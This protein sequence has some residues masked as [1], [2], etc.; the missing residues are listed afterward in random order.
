[1]IS[2]R[3]KYE[4]ICRYFFSTVLFLV[5]LP[6]LTTAQRIIG[7]VIDIETRKPVPEMSIENLYTNTV[8]TTN[9]D[10]KFDINATNGQLLEFK[11]AGYKTTRVRIP[12][13]TIPPY[14]KIIIE[15]FWAPQVYVA[16]TD[17]KHDSTLEYNLYKHELEVPKMNGLDMIQHPFSAMDS[18]NQQVWAFQDAYATTQGE[19]YID[20]TFN[21]EI[22]TKLTGLAGDSL[23]YYMR[24]FRPGYE[25]LRSMNEYSLYTYIRKTVYQFRHS[26]SPGR[27]SR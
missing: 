7:E 20:Y 13:G 17:W 10:G 15:H 23:D 12:E 22:V 24:R 26:H 19:K 16:G 25:Q 14:F 5:I 11:K 27:L 1:M 2:E 21:K 4:R 6:L 3:R 18:R 8:I 9:K